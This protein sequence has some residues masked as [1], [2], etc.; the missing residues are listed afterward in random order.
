MTFFC[1]V[2]DVSSKRVKGLDFF[3]TVERLRGFA[4]MVRRDLEGDAE[5]VVLEYPSRE[6]EFM[7]ESMDLQS[8]LLESFLGSASCKGGV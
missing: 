5:V 6:S 8:K 7:C 1:V 2:V 4:D 3:P